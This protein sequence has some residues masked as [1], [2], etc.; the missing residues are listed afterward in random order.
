[1]HLC[2]DSTIVQHCIGGRITASY[3]SVV[4]SLMYAML[5]TRPDIVYAVGMLG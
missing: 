4:G 2:D 5:G 1:M 3:P